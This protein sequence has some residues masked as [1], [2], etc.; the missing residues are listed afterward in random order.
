[1][2]SAFIP[3]Q[4]DYSVNNTAKTFG[5]SKKRV[6]FKFGL[7]NARAM[8]NGAV[9]AQCRGSEHELVF[10]WS[11]KTGKRQ[12]FLDGRD[13]HFSESGQNGW[14]VDRSWQHRMTLRDTTAGHLKLQFT[15]QAV[16]DAS[17]RPY[18]MILNG[19]SYFD[20]NQ[21]FQLGTPGMRVRER[22]SQSNFVLT[23]DPSVRGGGGRESPLTPEERRQI[24]A[25]KLESLKDLREQEEKK[26][27][28][29][30]QQQQQQEPPKVKDDALISFDDDA[31]SVNP[32]MAP[33]QYPQLGAPTTDPSTMDDRYRSN[34]WGGTPSYPI[35]PTQG[36]APSAHTLPHSTN[37]N[38]NQQSP[39]DTY[40]PSHN[41][42]SSTS[43]AVASSST[44]TPYYQGNQQPQPYVDAMG[45]PGLQVQQP[46]STMDYSLPSPSAQ[47][48]GSAPSFA[49][50]PQSYYASSYPTQ[51]YP[52]MQQ[53]QQPLGYGGNS[54]NPS[55]TTPPYHQPTF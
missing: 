47:S 31:P 46:L 20:F 5:F 49:Q 44:L 39:W 51:Q 33:G 32:H 48:Y 35:V 2:A 6:A 23:L 4:I 15:S 24:A 38:H 18:D 11:L 42:T 22:L 10:V 16:S 19:I 27:K 14:T 1:M 13:V 17:H 43:S 50:L 28:E 53:Q 30:Q 8:D 12:L 52:K 29:Q 45:R 3:Y 9:G 25:A 41:T 54:S 21:I 40:A 7:A 37:Y 36:N 55:Y 34:T 26:L